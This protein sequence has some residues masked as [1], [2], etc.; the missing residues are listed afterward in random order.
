MSKQRSYLLVMLSVIALSVAI[1]P[2]YAEVTLLKTNTS[3]YKGGSTIYFSGTVLDTDPPNVTILVFDPT[4]K[5]ILLASGNAD[6]NH[7]FQISVDTSTTDNVHKFSTKGVY[8]ATAFIANKTNGK[9]VSFVFSPDGSPIIPSSP[10]SLTASVVSSTEIDLRWVA[11]AS[12]GGTQS[13]GYQIGRSTDGGSTWSTSVTSIISTTFADV[14]LTPNTAYM[15]RVYAVNQAGPSIPS[16]V[17]TAVT[18]PAQ[19]QTVTSGTTST[20]TNSSP[21]TSLAEL[22]KQRLADAQR[23]QELLH[24]GNPSST[25]IPSGSIQTTNQSGKIVVNNTSSGLGVSKP[26]NASGN[27]L[28]QNGTANTSGNNPQQNGTANVSENNSTQNGPV[29][30]DTRL[31]IYPIISLVGVGIVIYIIYLRKKQ[32]LSGNTVETKKP[33]VVPSEVSSNQ[34]GVDNAMEILKNRLAKGEITV[35]EFKALKDELS[36]P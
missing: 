3:F 16:N 13:P 33:T 19:G 6:G 12:A 1:I 35:D 30:F 15:Y 36:E 34:N 21:T 31:A 20:G 17:V 18:M 4:G 7:Q 29:N 25:G 10:T 22:L 14:S 2:A 8:N 24:G 11:P 28:T 27:H 23:L 32:R 5:F 9:T 26:T